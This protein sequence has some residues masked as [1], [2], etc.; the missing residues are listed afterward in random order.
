MS[1]GSEGARPGT[2]SVA[3]P[4]ISRIAYQASHIAHQSTTQ[5]R[6]TA[7]EQR[8]NGSSHQPW[9]PTNRTNQ[10]LWF[11]VDPWPNLPFPSHHLVLLCVTVLLI[12]TAG[13]SATRPSSTVSSS[14]SSNV[15]AAPP[16]CTPPQPNE[17]HPALRAITTP[18]T[19]FQDLQRHLDRA[20]SSHSPT[21]HEESE[22]EDPF[23]YKKFE[24]IA[25]RP[26]PDSYT[27]SADD[28]STT[29]TIPK[30]RV[31]TGAPSP[32]LHSGYE[33]NRN[34]NGAN[35][36]CSQCSIPLPSPGLSEDNNTASPTSPTTPP[37]AAESFPEKPAS[38][39]SKPSFIFRFSPPILLPSMK[40]KKLQKKALPAQQVH[41]VDDHDMVL[42]VETSLVG[43]DATAPVVRSASN[44]APIPQW[45][46]PAPVPAPVVDVPPPHLAHGAAKQ[47]DTG[48]STNL[49]TTTIPRVEDDEF[50]QFITQMSFS[51][52]GSI[53][54][55][56]KKP[57]VVSPP[58]AGALNDAPA[59]ERPSPSSPVSSCTV[60]YGQVASR[61]VR[62]HG[63]EN[64]YH[65]AD[66]HR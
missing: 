55:A 20:P 2:N 30:L 46:S 34:L 35:D 17:T 48:V 39:F 50:S 13:T 3:A 44:I 62:F 12:A 42:D 4:L 52:R 66:H 49:K 28:D 8:P 26:A 45:K 9:R 23:T 61:R 64:T 65:D 51:K 59:S 56:G 63:A 41:Q 47:P 33:I 15:V 1:K 43:K 32:S 16:N 38:I 11:A 6:N 29:F 10:T 27:S 37:S 57:E 60:P 58:D 14:L 22:E 24:S 31:R 7:P 19:V 18:R 36:R 40:S 21:V 5:Y 25:I 53:M 54:L